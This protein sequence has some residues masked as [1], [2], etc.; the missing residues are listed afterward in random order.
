M[1]AM[2]NY[3]ENAIGNHLLRNTALS[4][5]AAVY[6]GLFTAAPG[7]AG[8][9]TEVETN[10]TPARGYARQAITFGAPTD[11]VF[12]NSGTLTFGAATGSTWGSV[13]H[14]AI[15][16]AAT[17]GNMLIYGTLSTP[18]TVDVGDT[19]TFAASQ[20]SVTFQ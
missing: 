7:E 3:L 4:S 18:K 17:T 9:G 5:P 19:A 16:D 13:T 15:F 1:S 12:T 20:L 14:F 2:T 11:G 10:G 8:G 6:V